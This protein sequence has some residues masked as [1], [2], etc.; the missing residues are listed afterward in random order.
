MTLTAENI[1]FGTLFASKLITNKV[2][3][4]QSQNFLSM[5][6]I[7]FGPRLKL[8]RVELSFNVTESDKWNL[9][10]ISSLVTMF[11]SNCDYIEYIF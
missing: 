1:L 2:F 8:N 3:F 5:T 11:S 10:N 6:L 7:V 9:E 4:C